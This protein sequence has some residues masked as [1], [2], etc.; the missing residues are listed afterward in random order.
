MRF[1]DFNLTI[2]SAGDRLLVS[3]AKP[4][5]EVVYEFIAPPPPRGEIDALRAKVESDAQTTALTALKAELALSRGA[6][7][8]ADKKLQEVGEKLFKWV[9]C[10]KVLQALNTK[11][12]EARR[13]QSGLRIRLSIDPSDS[14]L[15]IYPFEI[16]YCPKVPFR[17]HLALYGGVTIVR[18]MAECRFESPAAIEPPLSI[19]VVGASPNGYA[20]LD[21]KREIKDL[22]QALSLPGIKVESVEDCTLYRLK[23]IADIEKP[24]VLHFIGHGDFDSESKEGKIFF[25]NERNEPEGLT[26]DEFRRELYGI[27][28]LR[29]VTLNA[30][31]GN[32]S[33]GAD[34]F[35]SVAA[36]IFSLQIPA[37]VAMQFKITD[38][39]AIEFSKC[40]YSQLAL[41]RPVDD[42]VTSARSH[43]RRKI[44]GTPEWATPVLYLGT[45]DGDFLG[46]RLPLEHLISHSL[47]Q[48]RDGNWD[49]AQSTAMLALEQHPGATAHEARKIAA[50]ADQA[51]Q[52]SET[53]MQVF[54]VLRR[55][56]GNVDYPTHMI[57]KLIEQAKNLDGA[58]FERLLGSNLGKCK[59]IVQMAE[60]VREFGRGEFDS[61]IALCEKVPTHGL[62]DFNL[63]KEQ[64]LAE[65]DVRDELRWLD[66]IWSNGDWNDAIEAAEKLSS[67]EQTNLTRSQ[68]EME[69]KR[70][71]G[72][73]LSKAVEALKRDDFK[74]AQSIVAS[75][76][77]AGA[78]SNFELS[79]RAID[80]GAE[81]TAASEPAAI[82][83]LK[84][85]FEALLVEA[86]RASVAD[87]PAIRSVQ[88]F[89]G[90]IGSEADYQVG[91]D[92]Y[93]KG[94]FTESHNCFT[95]LG[96]YKDSVEKAARCERWMAIIVRLQSGQWDEAKRLLVDLKA[97]DKSARVQTYLLWCNWARMVI[98]VLETM[99]ASPL[100][101]D[102]SIPWEGADNPYKLFASL[103]IS[104]TSSMEQCKNDLGFDLQGKSGC[105]EEAE[106][107]GW[108]TL[109]LV[110]KRLLVDFLL[111]SVVNQ[112][113][114]RSLATRLRAVEEG[115]ELRMTTT[116]ELVSEL[117][118][119]G[120]IFLLLRK[121]YDQAISFFLQEAVTHPY[122]VT[123]LHHLGVAAAAKIHWL[124]ELGGD[125][126]QLAQAWE[127]LIL[128]WA[129]VFASDRF[130]HDWWVARRQV[131]GISISNQE[132][133]DVRLHLQRFW[134]ERIKAVTDI[135]AGL[136]ITF[137]AE[138]NGAS[139]VNAGK[140]IPLPEHPGEVA[141][142]GFIGA[143][144]LGLLD[145]V[146]RWTV[147]FDTE[148]LRTE[149][150][151]KWVCHYFSELAEPQTL[152]Q[153]SRYEEAID[154]LT[155]TRCEW[156]RRNDA[157]CKQA[158]LKADYPQVASASCPC[159]DSAN[160]AFSELPQGG[161]LLLTTAYDLLERAHCKIA[162]A[163][164]SS[165]PANN[166]KA[167]THWKTAVS[168]A[169]RHGGVEGLLLHIRDVII[170]RANFLISSVDPDDENRCLY[171]LDDVVELLQLS[172]NENWDNSDKA[173]K[174]ALIDHLLTRATYLSNRF[175]NYEDARRD[176]NWAYGME[177]G[178]L[179]AIHVLC[180]V[181]L[182][183]A[184]RL[185]ER[186]EKERA[187]A[188]MQEV[189][190]RLKEGDQMFPENSSIASCHEELEKYR[191]H[192]A[193]FGKIK[194]LPTL[195]E[196]TP[197][198][199]ETS[200]EQQKLT[201]LVEAMTNESQKQF[202]EAIKL[203]DEILQS[204]PTSVEV[205]ARME[206]CY[207][208]WIYY[209]WDLGTESP[210]KIRQITDEALKRFPD[211]E[212]L[213][214]FAK[215][216]SE[217]EHQ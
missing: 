50:L 104:P 87:N 107:N 5:G 13:E 152:F 198:S 91:L 76:P 164:V 111:Y 77:V 125:D 128:G 94:F 19:L 74:R 35:S 170:G 134:F 168:L 102:P 215:A 27:P 112:E 201:K 113:T 172:Y 62:F 48:L 79:K 122:N 84:S 217:E 173:L 177:P 25:V 140:G 56:G 22:K 72:K 202:A 9:F 183:F 88:N 58:E 11:H 43:V 208:S 39:A 18:S 29:L 163:A 186:G 20:K 45:P 142:V 68:Q 30:C 54:K 63:I 176:A 137:H 103:S 97:E 196:S 195:I 123:A 14:S 199:A 82:K 96:D 1:L 155:H 46:L 21:L 194:T 75:I 214:S 212:L 81:A 44:K 23:Q 49:I 52:F 108:D 145:A 143:K 71:I 169:R 148:S 159:F 158:L 136:D 69:S 205:R 153:D 184:G 182:Y 98:P 42:A 135:C 8:D 60:A 53:Y 106:R 188:L 26:G 12:D 33:Q 55:G 2:M 86:V 160:P 126:D 105:M 7:T 92:L 161:E 17:D 16:M 10:G 85:Q 64:A 78:P 204:E 40:F 34:L 59:E 189:E 192:I 151:Q 209:E 70:C 162:L 119:D 131:Y 57:E 185:R 24:H 154:A 41:G 179:R 144:A 124:E 207:R 66:T 99:A 47:A 80:M 83:A 149:G 133:Q 51:K 206:Y 197:P 117:K 211:S 121:D 156:L 141:V 100:V 190:E 32:V 150:W 171:V 93:T 213:S 180:K 118:E 127:Y 166:V 175:E 139:A 37:V 4:N 115:K 90:E 191:V 110:N 67:R 89:L 6:S 28:S 73:E 178:M 3:F 187:E 165:T 129:A 181:S 31:L 95:G 38:L 193:E 114:A 210:E 174:M 132:I 138:L 65:R 130:W 200:H 203:Y 167:L 216:A 157:R 61:V 116:Q 109:R 36:S 146:A 15:G 120:G 147:S 101:Y